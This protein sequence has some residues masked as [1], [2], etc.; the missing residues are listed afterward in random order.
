MRMSL[1]WLLLMIVFIS[2]AQAQK[3]TDKDEIMRLRESS[4]QALRKFDTELYLSFLTD[5]VQYTISNGTLIQ[6]KENLRK[7]IN[8]VKGPKMYWV[9]TP[10]EI[11]VNEKSGLAWE[12][13]TWKGYIVDS[14][15]QPVSSGKYSA[16]WMKIN[17]NWKI[18]SQLFVKLE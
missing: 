6:G 7:Y 10:I 5:D 11:N 13:G 16:M 15:Q 8:D 14:S 3:Q 4:N 9:R 2:V 1:P 12:A 17:G 18:K